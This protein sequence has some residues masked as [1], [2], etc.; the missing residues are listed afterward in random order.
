MGLARELRN[1]R[2]VTARKILV[3]GWADE[4]GEPFAMFAKPITCYD[5][6][7]LQ[8][9]HSTILEA[10]TVAAMVDMIVL[11]AEDEAGD[12]LF[13]SAEDRIDLMGEQTDVISDIANQMFASI[14]DAET[15][16]KN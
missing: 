14:V 8:K 3:K 9:K 6:N 15:A 7:E 4:S 2:S 13:T 12:K 5:I 10:P 1:R 11:K 16:E